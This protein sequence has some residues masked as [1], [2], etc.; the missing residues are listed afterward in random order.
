MRLPDNQDNCVLPGSS[1]AGK[2]AYIVC[3]AGVGLG[4]CLVAVTVL[5]MRRSGR[6]DTARLVTNMEKCVVDNTAVQYVVPG[7]DTAELR[8]Y[9]STSDGLRPVGDTRPSGR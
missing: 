4:A 7:P 5:R 8:L 9:V 6:Q 1:G 2:I 3:L